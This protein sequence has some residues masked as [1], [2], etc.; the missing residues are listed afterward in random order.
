MKL[1]SQTAQLSPI[2]WLGA[3]SKARVFHDICNKYN[4]VYFGQVRDQDD[5]HQLVQ[6]VTV[7]AKHRDNHYCVGSINDRGVVL[8]EREDLLTI[9]NS[10]HSQRYTWVILQVD[11]REGTGLDHVFIDGKHPWE[12]FFI[13]RCLLNLPVLSG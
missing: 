10:S 9:P 8:L 1:L 6:G 11:L 5:G 4:L 13:K 2:R 12:G 3:I 7:S